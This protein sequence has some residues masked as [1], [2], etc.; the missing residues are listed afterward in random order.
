MEETD[1]SPV[2]MTETANERPKRNKRKSSMADMDASPERSFKRSGISYEILCCSCYS[3]LF[4]Y[5]LLCSAYSFANYP[6]VRTVMNLVM[7][8]IMNLNLYL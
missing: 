5:S 2:P 3:L 6:T 8:C 7:N 4:H 1:G